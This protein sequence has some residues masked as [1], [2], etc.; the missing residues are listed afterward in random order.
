MWSCRKPIAEI[1]E[2]PPDMP[3]PEGRV[4]PG[5]ISLLDFILQRAIRRNAV[6]PYC[7][8][9]I[10]ED[11]AVLLI[12]ELSRIKGFN[13]VFCPQGEERNFLDCD[14]L[15]TPQFRWQHFRMDFAIRLKPKR[16]IFIECDGRDFH[17]SPERIA[18]DRRKDLA[19]AEAGIP[20]L[21]FTGSEIFQY[22]TAER[23]YVTER[24]MRAVED[25]RGQQ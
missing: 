24:L 20:L 1:E 13:F 18:N 11:V 5:G 6:A 17:S 10:E 7:E 4:E 16:Y 22:I 23:G 15:V 14:A 12:E 9:P 19:A 3:Y 2:P 25:I 8:S 21:R